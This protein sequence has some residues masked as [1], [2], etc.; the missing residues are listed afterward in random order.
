[1]RIR[2]EELDLGHASFLDVAEHCAGQEHL[3]LLDSRAPAGGLG[4]YSFLACAPFAVLTSKGGRVEVR[5]DGVQVTSPDDVFDTLERLLGRYAIPADV[6]PA[7]A[8]FV[9]GGIGYFAYEL[10]RQLEGLPAKAVDDLGVPDCHFGFYNW[11]VGLSH[12]DGRMFL[13]HFE[14]AADGAL[15]LPAVR[16]ELAQVTP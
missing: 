12:A 6:A 16:A 8:P 15:S 14:P 5:Q 3:A 13:C 11:V 7:G 9:G 2:V 10:S 4:R 1:M